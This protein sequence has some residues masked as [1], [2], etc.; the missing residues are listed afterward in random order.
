MFTIAP[1]IYE[2]VLVHYF[3][4]LISNS[5]YWMNYFFGWV[6]FFDVTIERKK[7]KQKQQKLRASKEVEKQ[8]VARRI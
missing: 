7:C 1:L 6:I 5:V 2:H 4:Y 3:E 8:E